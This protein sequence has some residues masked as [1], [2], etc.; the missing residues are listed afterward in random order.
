MR[1]PDALRLRRLGSTSECQGRNSEGMASPFSLV[2]SSTLVGVLRGK[3]LLNRTVFGNV[4]TKPAR[5]GGLSNARSRSHDRSGSETRTA[6]PQLRP[7]ALARMPPIISP[8]LSKIH[9]RSVHQCMLTGSFSMLKPN[10]MFTPVMAW[11]YEPRKFPV[12]DSS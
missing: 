12:S 8:F 5:A 9:E 11:V 2:S 10:I 4:I 3:Y 6:Q 7:E 1:R